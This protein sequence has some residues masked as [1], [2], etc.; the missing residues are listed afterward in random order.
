MTSELVTA[1]GL[2]PFTDVIVE[3]SIPKI[4]ESDNKNP[5]DEVP[6]KC[7]AIPK[8]SLLVVSRRHCVL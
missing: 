5:P 3:K 7:C 6:P 4:L 2:T 8:T 1:D